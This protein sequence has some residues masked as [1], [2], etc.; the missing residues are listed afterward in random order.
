MTALTSII[1]PLILAF[2]GEKGKVKVKVKVK[3][4][5]DVKDKVKGLAL[6]VG[7]LSL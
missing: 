4:K 5:T 2:K 7:F 6:K 1:F 3:V